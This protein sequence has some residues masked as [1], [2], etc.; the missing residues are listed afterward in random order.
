MS[1]LQKEGDGGSSR[2]RTEGLQGR[3]QEVTQL[4][5]CG[6]HTLT[7]CVS[8]EESSGLQSEGL[9]GAVNAQ[10]SGARAAGDMRRPSQ[11]L[12]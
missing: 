9:C 11:S 6:G 7:E 8:G 3:R 4:A 5:V 1:S 12:T 10:G 2:G